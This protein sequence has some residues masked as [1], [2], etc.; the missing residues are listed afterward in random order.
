MPPNH[1]RITFNLYTPGFV[2][3]VGWFSHHTSDNAPEAAGL[4][5]YSNRYHPA[6]STMSQDFLSTLAETPHCLK[7]GAPIWWLSIS[8]RTH[9]TVRKPI[10]KIINMCYKTRCQQ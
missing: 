8:N 2:C 7:T 10:N 4:G 5:I 1:P 9:K 3:V 6:N